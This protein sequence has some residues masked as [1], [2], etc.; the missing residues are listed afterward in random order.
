V[1]P[2]ITPYLDDGGTRQEAAV[3]VIGVAERLL[4]GRGGQTY[5]PVVAESLEKVTQ[6]AAGED[7]V[8]RATTLLQRARA[9]TQ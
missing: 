8:K 4:R 5:P 1:L 3:A 6:S 7:I 2:L 9:R